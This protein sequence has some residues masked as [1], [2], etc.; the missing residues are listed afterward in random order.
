MMKQITHLDRSGWTGY[1]QRAAD[2][3]CYHTWDYHALDRSGAPILFVYEEGENFIAFPL[4]KRAIAGTDLY[5]LGCV[6]GFSGPVASQKISQLNDVFIENFK[7][8]FLEL[9]EAE[10]YVSVFSA[11]HPFFNQSRLLGKFGGVHDNGLV[12]ALDLSLDISQQRAGYCASTRAQIKKAQNRGFRV[13]EKKG[14]EAVAVFKSIYLENM[15]RVDAKEYYLFD[16]KYFEDMAN[17]SD[18]DTRIFIVY[19]GGEPM[20][21][22]MVMF[23]NGIIQAHLVGTREEYRRFSPAKL[24]VEEITNIGRG[25]GM[26][27]FNL[28]GGL[29]FKD[30]S[31]L[32]WKR[33]FTPNTLDHKTWRFVANPT[34]YQQILEAKGIDENSGIDFFPL[35]RS[36]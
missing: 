22:T 19:D 2:F 4:I 20:A 17:A 33:S 36:R 26:H 18:F 7:T 14:P 15:K 10:N 16:D 3:D 24:L 1:I 9:L 11:L 12:V 32:E 8:A 23:T 34:V 29:G 13:E 5:D 30:D 6:Y 31:L 25:Y 28:G 27:Y 21:G 35:Y